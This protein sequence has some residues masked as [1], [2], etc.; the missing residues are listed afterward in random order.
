MSGVLSGLECTEFP[1][2]NWNG[3]RTVPEGSGRGDRHPPV[4]LEGKYSCPP[5]KISSE[6]ALS[7]SLGASQGLAKFACQGHLDVIATR[8]WTAFS[9][10]AGSRR[11][12]SS[13][14]NSPSTLRIL[15]GRILLARCPADVLDRTRSTRLSRLRFLSHLRS[16]RLLR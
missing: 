12:S 16:L 7:P 6:I 2:K 11:S 9:V 5:P 10:I 4:R 3:R 13:P 8:A 14:R 15:F 1:P